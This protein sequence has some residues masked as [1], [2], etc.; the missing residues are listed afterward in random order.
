MG[1]QNHIAFIAYT[2][3]C[4]YTRVAKYISLNAMRISFSVTNTLRP[5]ASYL[6]HDC[7]GLAVDVVVMLLTVHGKHLYWPFC[8]LISFDL[9]TMQANS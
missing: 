2:H 1:H 5:S 9:P 4:K 6:C 8:I 7:I 3:A